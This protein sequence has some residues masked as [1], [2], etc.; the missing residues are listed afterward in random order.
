MQAVTSF[1]LLKQS[2]NDLHAIMSWL[3][4]SM[5]QAII[6]RLP[7]NELEKNALIEAGYLLAQRMSW[8]VVAREQ[9]LPAINS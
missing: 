1:L 6:Q 9:L 8:D 7:R 3:M 4:G 5:A 2:N